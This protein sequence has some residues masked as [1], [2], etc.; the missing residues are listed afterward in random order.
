M[1][2]SCASDSPD[3]GSRNM[4]PTL[5]QGREG[6]GPHCKTRPL[7]RRNENQRG[8]CAQEQAGSTHTLELLNA[9][10]GR[11]LRAS[12]S[13]SGRRTRCCVRTHCFPALD[14]GKQ[15]LFSSPPSPPLHTESHRL[16][17]ESISHHFWRCLHLRVGVRPLL[18]TLQTAANPKAVG[19]Y[20][21]NDN[22]TPGLPDRPKIVQS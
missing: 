20:G 5:R 21:D 16:L 8:V 17:F 4:S 9:T 7:R 11:D 12:M 10:E 19:V 1:N 2:R 22:C 3:A 15:P 13:N 6:A 14:L 18:A